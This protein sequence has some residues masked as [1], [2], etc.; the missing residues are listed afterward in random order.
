MLKNQKHLHD[1]IKQS[2]GNM[3]RTVHSCAHWLISN[4]CIP[5]FGGVS[6]TFLAVYSF[7]YTDWLFEIYIQHV[8]SYPLTITVQV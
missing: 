7:E 5:H 8:D 1:S 3:Q 4:Y 6:D 2:H